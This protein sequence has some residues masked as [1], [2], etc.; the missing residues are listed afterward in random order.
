MAGHFWDELPVSQ[1]VV[2]KGVMNKADMVQP[3][4]TFCAF[5]YRDETA[6]QEDHVAMAWTAIQGKPHLGAF[7]SR[8]MLLAKVCA[9]EQLGSTSSRPPP[10]LP[11]MAVPSLPALLRTLLSCQAVLMVRPWLPT[12][13]DATIG[14]SYCQ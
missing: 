8:H 14:A 5:L 9:A 3:I 13:E 11:S 1:A 2:A 4:C 7:P 12:A 6:V 10:L